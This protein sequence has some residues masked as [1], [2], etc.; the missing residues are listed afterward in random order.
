MEIGIIG[1]GVIGRLILNSLLVFTKEG[2]DPKRISVS[3]RQYEDLKTY[4]TNFGVQLL[5]DN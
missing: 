5:Y 1:A 4:N 3:T 2:V